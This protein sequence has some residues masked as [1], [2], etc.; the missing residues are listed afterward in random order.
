MPINWTYN[1]KRV[2]SKKGCSITMSTIRY[3]A[4]LMFISGMFTNMLHAQVS[5]VSFTVTG[6]VSTPENVGIADVVVSDGYYVTTTNNDGR[7]TLQ[8]TSLAKHVFISVPADCDVPHEGNIPLFYKA[9]KGTSSDITVNFTLK[10]KRKDA[11][12]VLVVMADPQMQITADMKRF[13]SEPIPDIEKLKSSYPDDV[14]FIGMTAGDLLW[15]APKLYPEYVKAFEQLSF[16]FY[17]VIGN[18][19]Y[20]QLVKGNDYEA[21]H[22]FESYFGPAYYSFN[23]GDCHFIAL[24][25]IIYNGRHD[26]REDISTEQLNWLQQDLKYVDNNKLLIISMHSPAYRMDGKKILKSTAELV[27]ILKGYKVI[28]V[29]GHSH[30]MNK[31][32]IAKD[33][34]DYTLSPTMGNSWAG[35]INIDGT[36]NGYGVFEINGNQLVNQYFKSTGQPSGYQMKLYPVG[37]V[38]EY[39]KSVVAHVWNYSENW[40]VEVYE[41]DIY[42]GKMKKA[43]GFD[44]DAYNYFLGEQKP[45][46]KPKLEPA[47]TSNLFYFTPRDIKSEVKVVV[48]NC[49]GKTYIEYIN[50]KSD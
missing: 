23:R 42:K 8:S 2:S 48:T 31:A 18:H 28:F 15:D 20:D 25:N 16:P 41:D 12:L 11:Q 37:A 40:K 50:Y 29:S 30:R 6:K 24:D 47:K 32:V 33:I 17:Q 9:V 3:F 19:D 26:Y 46:R 45:S 43:T 22:Y 10:K 39:S 34:V 49:F 35:D 5:V 44:P 7:Y 4:L 36:P 21:S 38:R 27:E 14:A 1:Q 13:T